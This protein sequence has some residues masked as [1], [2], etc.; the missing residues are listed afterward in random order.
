MSFL[1]EG[2][3]INKDTINEALEAAALSCARGIRQHEAIVQLIETGRLT[4]HVA[5]PPG[6]VYR[7]GVSVFDCGISQ[8]SWRAMV[9][10]LRLAGFQTKTIWNN[11]KRTVE[12]F[13]GLPPKRG[14]E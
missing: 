14:E 13:W 4:S 3:P 12:L 10:R 9:K 1:A 6:P 11:G 5:Y 7:G 8:E 2:T